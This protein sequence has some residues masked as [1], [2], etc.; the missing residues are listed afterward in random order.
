MQ[1]INIASR[2]GKNLPF[3]PCFARFEEKKTSTLH[4]LKTTQVT[5]ASFL[6]LPTPA[7]VSQLWRKSAF[8]HG[9]EIKAGVGRT[10]N[11][12]R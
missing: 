1:E 4:S 5:V 3:T 11:E 8:L 9:C 2:T 7:F 12:A 10:G 6:V